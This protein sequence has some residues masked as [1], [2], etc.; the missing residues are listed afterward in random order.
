MWSARERTIITR[1]KQYLRGSYSVKVDFA[2]LEDLQGPDDVDV[3]F[4]RILED[5]RDEKR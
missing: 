3:T 2:E 1:T 4:R 5:A